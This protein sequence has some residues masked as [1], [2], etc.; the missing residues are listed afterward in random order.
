MVPRPTFAV[1]RRASG[2][3]KPFLPS[4]YL[5]VCFFGIKHPYGIATGWDPALLLLPHAYKHREA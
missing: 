4:G 1:D 5:L 2:M 3:L